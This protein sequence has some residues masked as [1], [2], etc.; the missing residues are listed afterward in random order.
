MSLEFILLGLLRDPAS[1][2]DMRREFDRGPR[3]FWSARL[4]QIYP[5]LQRMEERGWL[6][7]RDE[8]SHQGPARRVYRRS[9]AGTVALRTWLRGE[10]DLGVERL[11]YIGQLVF[12][13]ELHDRARTAKFLEAIRD[14]FVAFRDFLYAGDDELHAA[15]DRDP[16][17]WDDDSLHE[18]LCIRIGARALEG[19]IAACE[20]GLTLLH[21]GT[22][23]RQTT[24]DGRHA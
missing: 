9:R 18:L 21:A 4:S 19:K 12:L 15:H 16:S 14:Q 10:P 22:D 8:P 1:G 13:A 23:A 24:T 5:T 7:S 11:P 20:E 2:Y 17:Q 3:H 6:T